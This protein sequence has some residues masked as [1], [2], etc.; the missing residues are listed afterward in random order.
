MNTKTMVQ[1]AL[2]NIEKNCPHIEKY[3]SGTLV[4]ATSYDQGRYDAYLTVLE[5]ILA[6]ERS[7]LAETHLNNE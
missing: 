1:Q 7:K 4:T 6:E 2:G 3:N 5:S